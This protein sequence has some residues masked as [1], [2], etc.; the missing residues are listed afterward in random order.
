[1]NDSEQTYKCRL[2]D[3]KEIPKEFTMLS[4]SNTRVHIGCNG[5]VDPVLYGPS[6]LE[7]HLPGM[8]K[9]N[10]KLNEATDRLDKA[11]NDLPEPE[12]ESKMAFPENVLDIAKRD[13][14]KRDLIMFAFGWAV[15]NPKEAPG[16]AR[17]LFYDLKKLE[18]K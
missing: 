2:C 12:F 15:G 16:I 4:P 14:T 10:Q 7:E 11:V 8:L 1:M 3:T 17:D 18:D 13:E 5:V 9:D 6:I